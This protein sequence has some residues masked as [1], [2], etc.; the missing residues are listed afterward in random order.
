MAGLW[1]F[2][3]LTWA[4]SFLIIVLI[5]YDYYVCVYVCIRACHAHV[6]VSSLLPPW[7]PEVTHI[8]RLWK[9]VLSHAKAISLVPLFKF[10]KRQICYYLQLSSTANPSDC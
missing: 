8:A 2:F 3:F 4:L 1:V 7:V 10:S 6:E 5:S 9:Q